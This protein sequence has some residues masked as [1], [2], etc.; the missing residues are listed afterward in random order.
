MCGLKIC[1]WVAGILC[2]LSV[3]GVFLPV[4]AWESFIGF[5]GLEL[6]PDSPLFDYVVRVMSATF[7]GVGVFFLILAKD[8]M[9]Y[10][11]MVP[12]TVLAAV[13]LG[14]ICGITGFAVK[15]PNLWFLGDALSCLVLGVLIL[16]FWRQATNSR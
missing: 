9:K 1:L 5:F 16:V 8:P 10:G 13:V 4:S 7:V 14:V 15:M 2:L 11:I 12:F 3:F 6:L